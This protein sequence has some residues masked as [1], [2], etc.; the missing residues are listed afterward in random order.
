MS[1]PATSQQPASVARGVLYDIAGAT[2][3]KPALIV[4]HI[5]GSQYQIHLR[6][7]NGGGA[8]TAQVGKRIS[9]VINAAARRVDMTVQGGRFIEPVIGRP[10][11]IQGVV[12]AQDAG[13]NSITVDCG[14][15]AAV[16]GAGLP[17]V[18]KLTDARQKADQ[19]AIGTLVGFDV[20]DGATFTQK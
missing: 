15:S 17:V 9:G 1:A 6:Q 7:E 5:P 10:R 11:R 13:S 3:T 19:F 18:C 20:L 16:D 14:G 2:A 12:V 8:V 4:F